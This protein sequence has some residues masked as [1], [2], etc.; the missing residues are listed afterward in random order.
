MVYKRTRAGGLA[1]AVA[2]H[3]AVILLLYFQR[4]ERH[5]EPVAETWI[6][7]VKVQPPKPRPAPP[8]AVVPAPRPKRAAARPAPVRETTLVAIPAAP[9]E[10]PAS[11]AD[12]ATGI[13]M[14]AARRVA[15][16]VAREENRR[17]QTHPNMLKT[18]RPTKQERLARAIENARKPD[19]KTAYAGAGIFALI[20][21]AKN[22]L[23]SDP[24][25][26][27]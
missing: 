20:P 18:E 27:W 4:P 25:C 13:D 2:L 8:V 19:C 6:Q 24:S 21:L 15:A 23:S 10:A 22:A 7:L 17:A 14:D 16:E 11:V 5:A 12:K 26:R 1:V 9:T 3:A